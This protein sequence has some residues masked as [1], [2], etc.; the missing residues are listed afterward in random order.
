VW[1]RSVTPAYSTSLSNLDL[2]LHNVAAGTFAL[3]S[4]VQTS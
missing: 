2:T 1:L 4:V 3:G